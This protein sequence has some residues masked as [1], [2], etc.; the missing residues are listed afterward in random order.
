LT[1]AEQRQ[2]GVAAR[3]AIPDA[4]RA[5]FSAAICRRIEH[6][7]AFINARTV[8]AYRSLPGEVDLRGLDV[9]GKRVA[10]P[11]SG[12]GGL[13]DA[14]VPEN[15]TFLCGRFG[16]E[17]PDAAVSRLIK[18]EEMDLVLVPCTV[19]DSVGGRIGMG[20]GYYDRYLPQCTQAVKM[21]VAF[22]AQKMS[23]VITGAL[24]VSMDMAVTEA[25]AYRFSSRQ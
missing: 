18:P 25:A 8:L 23:A 11:C 24:D 17:E 21:L 12:P 3:L 22:E 4:L 2:A 14:Y 20:G 9:R 6:T 7:D 10:Y 19:F 15:G 16:I 1:A 5:A 13:M